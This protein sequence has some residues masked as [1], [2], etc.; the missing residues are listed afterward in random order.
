MKLL[1]LP[2]QALADWL[3]ALGRDAEVFGPKATAEGPALASLAPGETPDE[4]PGPPKAPLK[5]FF[6]PQPETLAVFSTRRDDPEAHVLRPPR[7]EAGR[8]VVLAGVR[9]CDARSVVLNALPF[10][11]DPYFQ[12]RCG[13]TV[14]IGAACA[15]TCGTCFC[16][17]TGGDPLGTEGLD[18][19]LHPA[20]GGDLLVEVLTAKGEGAAPEAG[21]PAAAADAEGL[22]ARR[23]ASRRAAGRAPDPR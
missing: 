22:A 12:A 5:T 8:R 17:W 11:G 10:A 4:A 7:L 2:R 6:F 14:L 21:R 3:A 13:A 23:E 20:D 9:P 1:R 16:R 18:L 15:E 19:L